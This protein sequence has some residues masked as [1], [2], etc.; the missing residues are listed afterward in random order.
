MQ[1]NKF[2]KKIFF[3]EENNIRVNST[4][5]EILSII[6]TNIESV[7]KFR[8]IVSNRSSN[9]YYEGYCSDKRFFLRRILKKGYSA[10]LPIISG[11]INYKNEKSFIEISYKLHLIVKTI[12]FFLL[13]LL[14]ILFFSNLINNPIENNQ[15]IIE[16][17]KDLDLQTFEKT[18]TNFFNN[19][20]KYGSFFLP[21]IMFFTIYI[22]AFIFFYHQVYLSKLELLSFFN[23]KTPHN[24]DGASMSK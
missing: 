11:K 19:R 22:S 4:P 9:K 8:L 3:I 12:L 1:M 15:I 6:S 24:P 10:Y 5:Q 20:I 14:L 23:N 16:K 13:M 2:I 7:D 17:I 18:D 21:L